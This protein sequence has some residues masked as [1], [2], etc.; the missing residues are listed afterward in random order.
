MLKVSGTG[1]AQTRINAVSSPWKILGVQ[2]V[3]ANAFIHREY[4][5]MFLSRLKST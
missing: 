5:S 2:E 4:Y 1:Q 3:L